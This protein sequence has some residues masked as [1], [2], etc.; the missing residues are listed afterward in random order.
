[1]SVV[2]P[3]SPT[4]NAAS[5]QAGA[6]ASNAASSLSQ[7]SSDYTRFL[8]LLTAQI[9]NQDPLAPMDSGQ[10]ITQL[11]QLSQVEQS[12]KTN[13]NLEGIQGSMSSFSA[14]SGTNLLGHKVTVESS[15]MELVNGASDMSYRLAAPAAS[16]SAEIRDASGTL[17]RTIS[18][19]SGSDQKAVELKWDGLSDSG[20][21]LA[22][23][24]YEVKILPLGADGKPVGATMLQQATVQEMSLNYG[25][26]VLRLSN[27]ENVPLLSALA[28]R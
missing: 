20:Q 8:K 19:L 15:K 9:S 23:G 1:M 14:L 13:S 22:D 3:V 16:V 25:K 4:Q 7:L 2:S 18:N 27:G 26:Q 28:V 10:F 11:A 24:T 5:T 17:L 6:K 12:V 21:K